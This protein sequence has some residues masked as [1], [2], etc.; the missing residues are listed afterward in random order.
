MNWFDRMMYNH[1][2]SKVNANYRDPFAKKEPKPTIIRPADYFQELLE[3]DRRFTRQ[4]GYTRREPVS[5]NAGWT[6]EWEWY[7]GK[8]KTARSDWW[9]FKD[10]EVESGLAYLR[11]EPELYNI[12][13][14]KILY[15][16]REFGGMGIGRRAMQAINNKC[17][18]TNELATA[19]HKFS[20][21][22]F[23]ED[24][25][26]LVLQLCPNPLDAVAIIPPRNDD[27]TDD[28]NYSFIRDETN[29]PLGEYNE[30]RLDLDGLIQFYTSCDY[31]RCDK[32]RYRIQTN[33]NGDRVKVP[34]MTGRSFKIDRPI[35]I[36]PEEHLDRLSARWV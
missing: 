26:Y 34:D 32:R 13:H 24:D 15:V 8:T 18:S 28:D 36:Y 11:L 5:R 33:E 22:E 31:V 20:D 14:V 10:N 17:D 16:P 21:M 1:Q 30:K 9:I 23:F 25:D 7:K 6:V 27:W 3:N 4:Y 2:M 19:G 29:S 35:L 12:V